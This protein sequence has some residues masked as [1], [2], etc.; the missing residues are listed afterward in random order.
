MHNW[1]RRGWIV[2]PS[3]GVYRLTPE[4]MA[5]MALEQEGGATEAAPPFEIE[6]S[7]EPEAGEAHGFELLNPQAA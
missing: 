1:K 7:N 2:N 5:E 6:S 3:P 4:G